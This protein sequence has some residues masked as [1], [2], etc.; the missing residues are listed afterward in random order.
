MSSLLLS[1]AERDYITKG[2]EKN[3]RSD[4]R[5]RSDWRDI[6][7]RT[8][9]VSQANGSARCRLGNLGF[10]TDIL[11]GVKAEIGQWVPGEPEDTGRIVCNVECSPSA[12][13]EFEG[14]GADEINLELSQMLDRFLNGSSGGIDFKQLCIIP[15][16]AYWVLY[17]DALV[18]DYDGNLTDALFMTTR[19][20]LSDTRLPKVVVESITDDDGVVQQ[21]FEIVDD[22]DASEPVRG[23]HNIPVTVTLY[24]VG[25]QYIVDAGLQEELCTR[26]KLTVAV[27]RH[28]EL[29]GIQKTANKSGFMPAILPEMLEAAQGQAIALMDRIDKV[30]ERGKDG[31]VADT[32]STF[33]VPF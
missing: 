1:P 4:G 31:D 15:K 33:L 8:S 13:Q 3:I 27:N 21:E 17:V 12:M 23:S 10:G 2:V 16:Q 26:A 25:R 5:T 6:Q 29:C 19:A 7:L 11:V 30:I 28:G 22:P 14:R 20:A 18:L 9:L 32:G 24:Q